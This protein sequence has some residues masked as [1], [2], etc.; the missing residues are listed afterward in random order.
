VKHGATN[1]IP[2][3]FIPGFIDFVV[4]GHEHECKPEADQ[5]NN[6]TESDT[7]CTM[8][9]QPGSSVATQLQPGEAEAKHALILTVFKRNFKLDKIP[10]KT[11]RPFI[12]NNVLVQEILKGKSKN[13]TV[14]KALDAY[15]ETRI[16]QLIRDAHDLLTGHELQPLEPLI[17]IRLLHQDDTGLFNPIRFSQKYVNKIANEDIVILS[18]VSSKRGDMGADDMDVGDI[19]D[20]VME[21]EEVRPRN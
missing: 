8:V 13:V 7:K 17:R 11:V 1:Y 19:Q 9:L 4:W 2:E 5:L 3:N 10:L 14:E 20:M 15:L 21:A 6:T 16:K 18:K 12:L